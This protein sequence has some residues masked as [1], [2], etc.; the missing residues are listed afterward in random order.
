[1][2]QDQGRAAAARARRLDELAG[3]PPRQFDFPDSTSFWSALIN[4]GDFPDPHDRDPRLTFSAAVTGAG[5]HGGTEGGYLA[6]RGVLEAVW[7]R[8]LTSGQ[9]L[10]RCTRIPITESAVSIPAIQETSRADGS[11]WGAIKSAWVDAGD[12]VD[13]A[14]TSRPKFRSINLKPKKLLSFVY[15]TNELTRDAGAF[16]AWAEL[17]L[18]DE[19]RHQLEQSIVDGDGAGKPLGIANADATISIP[20]ESGQAASTILTENLENMLT[21]IWSESR[22][23]AVWLTGTAAFAQIEHTSFSNGRPTVEYVDGEPTI[24]GRPVLLTEYTPQ[25]G[26]KGDIA[27]VDFSQVVVGERE[28]DIV[29]SLHLRWLQDE[30]VLRARYRVDAQPLW[31][32]ALTPKNSAATQSFAVTVDERA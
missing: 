8:T 26:N 32:S 5:E 3:R 27:L 20:K 13:D 24:A 2:N 31:A 19:I 6:S 15:A 21:R 29:S 12:T 25:L 4:A 18:S 22:R 9:I 23:R 28:R 10:S 30:Q 17:A 14:D 16:G 7:H 1:M 11:R